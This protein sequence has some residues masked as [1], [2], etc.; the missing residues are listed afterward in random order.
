[1]TELNGSSPTETEHRE[2]ES[3]H[4]G[5]ERTQDPLP[6]DEPDEDL[7]DDPAGDTMQPDQETSPNEHIISD[8][9]EFSWSGFI[10]HYD[11]IIIRNVQGPVRVVPSRD[12]Q[13]HIRTT[14]T[15]IESPLDSVDIEFHKHDNGITICSVYTDGLAGQVNRCGAD[16]SGRLIAENNDVQVSYELEIPAGPMLLGQTATGNMTTEDLNNFVDFTSTS[17]SISIRTQEPAYARSIS[18]ALDIRMDPTDLDRY[19]IDG[20]E[21]ITT[22]GSVRISVPAVSE[23]DFTGST[24]AGT[25]NTDFALNGE[26]TREVNGQVNGGGIDIIAETVAGSIEFRVQ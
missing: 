21:F 26:G 7:N 23:V 20:L 4:H 24:T 22:S 12:G 14:K 11:T 18:G 13:V 1:M 5:E 8:D 3:P 19:G 6:I 2:S 10:D 16:G 17:G 25:I 9:D 15:S